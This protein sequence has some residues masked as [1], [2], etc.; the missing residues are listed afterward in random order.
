MKTI[1]KIA[2]FVVGGFLI[3]GLLVP[4]GFRIARSVWDWGLK[5]EENVCPVCPANTQETFVPES[6]EYIRPA[7][8]VE[9]GTQ[10]G[11]GT[12][13]FDAETRVWILSKFVVPS[14]ACY[15]YDYT[16]REKGVQNAPFY[17]GS[18]L[19]PV[20]G[21]PF[22]ICYDTTS[23]NCKPPVEVNFFD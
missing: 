16:G 5:Q 13:T 12:L 21:K 15:A 8:R 4:A 9:S 10:V 2:L 14:T 11:Y 6:S 19:N 23:V 20:D 17:V 7:N 18:E 22:S 1:G 3:L